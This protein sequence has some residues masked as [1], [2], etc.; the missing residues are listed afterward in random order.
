MRVANIEF[1]ALD[2][3]VVKIDCIEDVFAL[4]DAIYSAPPNS[5]WVTPLEEPA[6]CPFHA[7]FEA[8]YYE[9]A[10]RVGDANA[11]S[12]PTT[13][14]Y[15]LATGVRPSDAAFNAS[16]WQNLGSGYEEAGTTS[17]CPTAVLT[18][19][20][21]SK[22]S[23]SWAIGSGIDLD[24]VTIGT[25]AII[26]NEVIRVDAVTDTTLT[27]GRGCL[28]SVPITHSNGARIYFVDE[29]AESNDLEYA[30]SETALIKLTPI[31]S[32][33]ELDVSLAPQQSVSIVARQKKPY[34][35]GMFRINSTY[36]PATIAAATD[37]VVTWAH[38]DRLQQTAS[39]L[40]NTAGSIGPEAGTTYTVEVRTSGGTLI[41]QQTGISGTTHT[42]TAATLSTN[43]GNLTVNLFSIRGGIQ[44]LR[45]HT[46]VIE[47]LAP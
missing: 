27:V 31:T 16:I 4:G 23:T 38:R 6:A 22:T 8:P 9:M 36:Y 20:V 26:G 17:F 29:F 34:P 42:F 11:E 13:A 15:I 44:S 18:S 2:N 41:S 21:T 10:Q 3:N 24:Q 25:Y 33:G 7:V 5:E 37:M 39:I 1:G 19:A 30:S 43:Y 47:R 28:D 45:T 40:D 35:P 12:L 14:G 32:L 46:H